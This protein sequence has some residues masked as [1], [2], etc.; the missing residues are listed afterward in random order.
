MVTSDEIG[1]VTVFAGLEPAD[2]ERLCRVA[3]DISL[4][5]GEY[6]AHEG[7][8]PAL[9]G[10]LEGRIEAVKLVDGVERVIGERRPGDVFGEISITL[11][12]PHPA[13]F[14]AAEASR[15]LKIEPHDY[16]AVAAVAPEVREAGRPACE[17]PDR[18]PTR[19]SKHRLRVGSTPGD[20]ARPPVGRRLR[21][22]AAL[23]RPEPDP[24]QMAPA[25]RGG[26]RGGVGGSVAGRGRLSR[27]PR[28]E[29]Q[30]GR[31]PATTTCR[32]A[33]GH[34]DRARGGGVRHSDR[35]RGARRSGGG[36]LRRLG[37]SQDDRRRAR[38]ARR[39]GGH[40]VADRELPRLPLGR[41]G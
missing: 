4:G 6:A 39:P 38:G 27:S 41:I 33:V 14:R 3:A 12:T 7:D 1:R 26:G 10:L 31:P 35:R 30:D 16:H 13:G 21:R 11:G 22:A 37:R 32:G 17:Q 15:A 18:R 40:V 19:P 5:S 9:F 2:R 20:R 8:E 24:V 25:R 36:G 34:R 23:P 29:R 28:R